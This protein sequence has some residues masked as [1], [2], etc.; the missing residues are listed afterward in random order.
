MSIKEKKQ[1]DEKIVCDIVELSK[2]FLSANK[3]AITA[4]MSEYDAI[5]NADKVVFNAVGKSPLELMDYKPVTDY[6]DCK[7]K[8][9]ALD[10]AISSIIRSAVVCKYEDSNIEDNI[11]FKDDLIIFRAETIQ[12]LLRGDGILIKNNK[13]ICPS[14]R[15]LGFCSKSTKTVWAWVKKKTV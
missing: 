2:V 12:R 9:T 4:G 14:L 10:N 15:R 5:M 1:S 8:E 13:T 7:N 11:F 3:M 6:V